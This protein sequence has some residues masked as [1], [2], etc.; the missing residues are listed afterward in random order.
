MQLTQTSGVCSQNLTL[1]MTNPFEIFRINHSCCPNSAWSWNEARGVLEV[2]AIRRISPGDEITRTYL[3][4]IM[5]TSSKRNAK[6][7]DQFQFRY[8]FKLS[9]KV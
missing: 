8:T 2:R 1:K 5:Q 6:L 7:V 3:N 9:P 4:N